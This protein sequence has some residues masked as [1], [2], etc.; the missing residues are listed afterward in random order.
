MT[1]PATATL[2]GY[3]KAWTPGTDGVVKGEAIEASLQT[4]GD[5]E[6]WRG[7]LKGKFVL[8]APARPITPHFTPQAGRYTDAE[9]DAL[10]RQPISAGRGR[11]G[12]PTAGANPDFARDW[13]AFLVAEGVL[14]TLEPGRGD[15]G[16]VF[17]QSGG[18]RN[19]ADPPTVPQ[20]VL[21]PEHY[22]RLVRILDQEDPGRARSGDPATASP[23]RRRRVQRDRRDPR[24]RQGRRTRDARRALRFV[25]R[26]HRRHRQRRRLGGDDGGDADPQGHWPA[27][28]PDRAHGPVG[29]RGAGLLRLAGLRRPNTSATGRRWQL[30]PAH[31]KFSGYFNVDNGTR[32]IRGVYLQGN[33]AVAPIFRAWMEPFA[34]LGMTTL[35]IR[36]TGGTDHLSF[37]AVG[38]P[39][40]QFIQDELEYDSRTHHSNMDVYDRLQA[41]DMMKNAVIVASF[42]YHAANRDQ[43]LPRKPMPKPTTP[44]PTSTTRQ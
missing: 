24:H 6:A 2:I 7:K 14:A 22:N 13:T 21:A 25:A 34:N 16:T 5:L 44:Q 8:T 32:Q 26:R 4:P 19:E 1:A 18:S 12:V 36:N 42:V 39:G 43:L 3:P 33:E 11:G 40:F 38:L 41:E 28:A 23:G 35:T 30:K 31:A 15:G 29:R 20:V 10:A 27:A 17:V 37:D 9:L